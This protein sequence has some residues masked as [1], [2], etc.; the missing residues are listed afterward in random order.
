MLERTPGVVAAARASGVAYTLSLGVHT[1]SIAFSHVGDVA[2]ARELLEEAK[3]A[4]PAPDGGKVS[5][6]TAMATAS[7]QL[8][9][10]DEPAAVATLQDAV[11]A[12][13]LDRGVDRRWWRQMLSL[14]YVLL[15]ESR[16]PLGR[17]PS[18]VARWPWPATWPPRWWPAAPARPAAPSST[19]ARSGCP[20]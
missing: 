10:G 1:A 5:V 15:P 14:S 2:M 3:A 8:A 7:L 18:C 6:H 9:E 17:A 11:E 20:T 19:C 16:E 13:G 12:H 4:A